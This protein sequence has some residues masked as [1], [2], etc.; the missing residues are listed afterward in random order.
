MFFLV[1]NIN[2]TVIKLCVAILYAF[3][4]FLIGACFCRL[5]LVCAGVYNI[6]VT[7]C[8]STL[9]GHTILL[10]LIVTVTNLHIIITTNTAALDN[11]IIVCMRQLLLREYH[12]LVIFIISIKRRQLLTLLTP[13]DELID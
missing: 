7:T 5:A 10:S 9:H 13:G 8:H 11:T 2:R 4:V 1:T 12:R 6:V 3:G